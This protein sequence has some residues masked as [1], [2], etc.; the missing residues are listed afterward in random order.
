[1]AHSASQQ[2]IL[3][4][5]DE[6][7]FRMTLGAYLRNKHYLV[8]E[9]KDGAEGL[10]CVAMFQPD[11]VVC[12]LHMPKM[13]G[14]QVI[15][16]IHQRYPNIP[17]IVISGVARFDDVTQALREGACDYLLKPITDWNMVTDAI[18][19]SLSLAQPGNHYQE[20]QDH[21][22]V[23]RKDDYV[24]TKLMYMLQKPSPIKI[25][26][27][28]IDYSSSTPLLYADFFSV[29]SNLMVV[30][31]ELYAEMLDVAFVAAM[32]KFLLDPP[33][34]QYQQE[35]NH[36]FDSPRNVLS[37]LNW[38]ICQ[39]GILCNINCSVLLLSDTMDTLHFANAGLSSPHWLK[40]AAN[41]SLGLLPEVEYHNFTKVVNLPFEMVV[42]GEAENN[43][44]L[45][46]EKS[47]P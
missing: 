14:H 33:Y 19:Q 18:E 32:I 46:I 38:H 8:M 36:I 43:L 39:S 41:L 3:V 44:I 25:D 12:D 30:I 47:L 4:I 20:L 1:M 17:V 28:H 27:W 35:G 23:L 24:A 9:S 26:K 21:R 29:E 2:K 37:Y 7:V 16:I 34:R 10:A 5:E 6:A 31:V 15:D 11:V 40:Q 13:S 45:K 22:I 42:Q